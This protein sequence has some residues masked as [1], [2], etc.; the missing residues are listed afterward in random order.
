MA[1]TAYGVDDARA[2]SEDSCLIALDQLNDAENQSLEEPCFLAITAGQTTPLNIAR[3]TVYLH[4]NHDKSVKKGD[5]VIP[6]WT[7]SVLDLTNGSE[8]SVMAG[9]LLLL[10]NT[11]FHRIILI[12]KGCK[13]YRHWDEVATSSTFAVPG[14]LSPDWP[15]AISRRTLVKFLPILLHSRTLIHKSLVVFDVLDMTMVS[16]GF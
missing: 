7:L 3:H 2:L 8:V 5:I 6:S 14:T 15:T 4:R 9:R 12:F 11:S 13:G 1:F 10:D 16:M